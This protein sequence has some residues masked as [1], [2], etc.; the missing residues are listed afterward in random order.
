MD[1]KADHSK[2]ATVTTTDIQERVSSIRSRTAPGPDM[3]H[4]HWLLHSTPAQMNPLLI[5]ET[6]TEWLTEGWTGLI[7]NRPN[8]QPQYNMDAPVE[9]HDSVHEQ[10]PEQRWQLQAD[11]AVTHNCKTGCA[12]PGLTTRI[13]L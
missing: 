6:H 12:L 7:I 8:Y 10:S 3:T 1:V 9:T 5:D 11:R 4:T 13:S 2:K